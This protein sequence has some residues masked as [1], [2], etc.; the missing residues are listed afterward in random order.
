MKAQLAFYKADGNLVD[1]LVRFWTRSCY[2]HVEL[3]INGTWY[4]TSPRDLEV[5]AKNINPRDGYWDFVDVEIDYAYVQRFFN[6]TKGSKYDWLGI[7]LS[8]IFPLHIQ[9]ERR[10]YCSEWCATALTLVDNNINP[11]QLYE[12]VTG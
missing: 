1:K 7:F 12:K 8:Q 10:Y 2:S 3:V 9:L 5:R 6:R 11:Q 4:S